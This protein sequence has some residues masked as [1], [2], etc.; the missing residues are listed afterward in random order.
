GASRLAD[1]GEERAAVEAAATAFVTAYGT[2]DFRNADGYTAQ[3]VAL[4]G[5]ALQAALADALV[6]PQ[7]LAQQRTSS[8]RIESVSVTA[9][10][11]VAATASVR[12]QHERTWLD[13]FSG[14]VI[15]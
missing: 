9:L 4:T 12:A 15:Q 6:D 11:E 5:G 7:A 13:A 2:F 14:E 1:R 8:A 3:L 10:S